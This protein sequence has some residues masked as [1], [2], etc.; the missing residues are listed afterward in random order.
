MGREEG[1]ESRSS[2]SAIDCRT[3][4]QRRCTS[5]FQLASEARKFPTPP[6]TRDLVPRHKFPVASSLTQPQIAS[7]ALKSGQFIKPQAQAGCPKVLPH[8][9]AMMC[10]SVVPD[11]VQRTGLSLEDGLTRLTYNFTPCFCAFHLGFGL[12]RMPESS[13]PPLYYGLTAQRLPSESVQ[14]PGH[15]LGP[16]IDPAEKPELCGR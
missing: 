2:P 4:R 10:R 12:G 1:W 15:C 14:P 8:R 6:C 7:S 13:C 3:V 9:P 5:S 11:H 16:I